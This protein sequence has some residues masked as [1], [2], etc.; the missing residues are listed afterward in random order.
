MEVSNLW[1][2][3]MMLL[4]VCSYC[5]CHFVKLISILLILIIAG[6]HNFTGLKAQNPCLKTLLAIG[7]WN[8]GSRKYSV[9]KTL[10]YL[11][12]KRYKIIILDG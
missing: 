1:I 7:G 2:V 5:R 11:I 6:F 3:T 12:C 9:V 10:I 8:E 4:E